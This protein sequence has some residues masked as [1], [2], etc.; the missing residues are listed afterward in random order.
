MLVGTIAK[1][2]DRGTEPPTGRRRRIVGLAT[3][4]ALVI[5]G[6][7]ATATGLSRPDPEQ[8]R[9]VQDTFTE[10]AVIHLGNW[11]PALDAE[12]VTCRYRD[13][14][15]VSETHASE[16][17][18]DEPLTEDELIQECTTGTDIARGA[19]GDVAS[20]P[21]TVC[22][23]ERN[24]YPRP[25]VAVGA[26]E[27]REQ[28]LEPLR[29]TDLEEINRMRAIEVT[30]LAVPSDDECP[31]FDEARTWAGERLAAHGEAIEF[32]A[33]DPPGPGCWRPKINWERGFFTPMRIGNQE[34][35]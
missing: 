15:Q 12:Q 26:V 35:P 34:Q 13:T 2:G 29:A 5:G 25:V 27:C 24:P 4:A 23:R 6:S 21:A 22:A 32:E 10:E 20:E 33:F 3:A 31:S 30:V 16:F 28:E 1:D 18:L 19:T 17:P 8:A 14:G 11:R 7:V 9:Q